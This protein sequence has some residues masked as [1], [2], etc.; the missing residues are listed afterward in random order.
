MEEILLFFKVKADKNVE[1]N[2]IQCVPTTLFYLF[3]FPLFF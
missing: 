1:I 2:K 3:A